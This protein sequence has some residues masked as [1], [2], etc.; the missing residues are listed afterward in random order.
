LNFL[1]TF[2]KNIQI[3]NLKKIRPM[4]AELFYNEAR[5]DRRTDMAKL[6]DDFASLQPHL[7][8]KDLEIDHSFTSAGLLH[9]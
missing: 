6:I 2:S 7:K 3:P 5:T 9:P 8:M 4:G 1:D